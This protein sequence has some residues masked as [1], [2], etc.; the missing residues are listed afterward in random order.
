MRPGPSYH[1][2]QGDPLLPP[3]GLR[4]D[5]RLLPPRSLWSPGDVTY[6]PTQL[7]RHK[8]G[9]GRWSSPLGE[10]VGRKPCTA[11][12]PSLWS[13][14]LLGTCKQPCPSLFYRRAH[15]S[16]RKAKSHKVIAARGCWGWPPASFLS[17]SPCLPILGH[18]G[19]R[20][21]ASETLLLTL[22]P[23][24]HF[25]DGSLP[26]PGLDCPLHPLSPS[27]VPS[28]PQE[29]CSGVSFPCI[30]THSLS[31]VLV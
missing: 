12:T 29:A 21:R 10:A 1:L 18:T 14:V 24:G 9:A 7:K 19:E 22:W 6:K 15:L 8:D 28:L 2:L 27:Q 26:R 3:Q 13:Q 30:P 16:P 20:L 11:T 23:G 5:P 31:R 17:P 25:V 4:G